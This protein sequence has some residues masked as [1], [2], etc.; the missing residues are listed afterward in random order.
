MIDRILVSDQCKLQAWR[1]QTLS[2]LNYYYYIVQV[3][4]Q[5]K[6]ILTARSQAPSTSRMN[7]CGNAILSKARTPGDTL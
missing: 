2:H 6:T 4:V 1:Q 3:Q 5:L 7:F